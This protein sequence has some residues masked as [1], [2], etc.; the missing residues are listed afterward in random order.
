MNVKRFGIDAPLGLAVYFF[1]GLGLLIHGYLNR[2]NYSV[3]AEMLIGV[4]MIIGTGFFLHTT[5]RG[6]YLLFDQLIRQLDIA[7]D[8]Q[9]LDLGC[10]RGALLT[11][12]AQQLVQ[13]GQVTGIDLWHSRDQSRNGLGTAQ[14]NLDEL[15]VADRVEL[16]TGDMAEL[17][18]VDNHFDVVTTSFAFH[19]IQRYKRRGQAVEE[20][21]RVL[22]P[23]GTIAIMDT[24][25][26][27]TQYRDVFRANHVQITESKNLGVNGWWAGPLTG[28]YLVCGVKQ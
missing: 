7:P 16:V 12:I 13:P 6:K 18:F 19:N 9:I 27:A 21:I 23:G 4:L 20:A 2:M 28:S 24:G 1:G 11:R 3:I 5:V 14:K 15:N 22:K 8:A 17:P 25:H 10:G 26:C